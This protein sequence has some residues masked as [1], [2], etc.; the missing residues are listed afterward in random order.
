M[1]FQAEV[2]R[3]SISSG[4]LRA[5]MAVGLIPLCRVDA[6]VS[7]PRPAD[8]VMERTTLERWMNG[9]QQA[10]FAPWSAPHARIHIDSIR[11]VG[12]N[13]ALFVTLARTGHG[14]DSATILHDAGGQ[15]LRLG[16]GLAAYKKL[17]V[18]AAGDSARFERS[19]RF[20]VDGHLSL[21]ATRLWDLVRTFPGAPRRG[22]RWTDTL[23]RLAIDPPYRQSLIGSRVSQILGDTVLDGRRLWVVRDSASVHYEERFE[24]HERTL[25]VTVSIT[26]QVAGT[27]RG[28][29]LYDPE[30]RLFRERADTTNL[31]GTAVLQ[32][33]D[34]RSFRTPTRF[35]R[36]RSWRLYDATRYARYRDSLNARM[37]S[38]RGGMVVPFEGEREDPERVQTARIAAGDT[39]LL[40]HRLS[41]RAY[42]GPSDTANVRA[43]LAFMRDPGLMWDF[44]LPRDWLYENLA[45]S[46]TLWPPALASGSA[47]ERVGC[48]PD[49]C[50]LLA[51]QW[52]DDAAREPRLRDV[53]LIA[54]F[55]LDPRRWAD[56][57]LS[58]GGDGRRPLLRDAVMLARGVGATWPAAAK[59]EMPPPQ[60]DWRVWLEWMNGKN[61][62]ARARDAELARQ[63]TWARD[64]VTRPRVQGSHRTAI[65]MY[66]IRTGRD[67]VGELRRAYSS[68][69][70]DTARLVFGTMLQGLGALE[71][72]DQQI[73]EAFRSGDPSRGALARQ[74]LLA[75]FNREARALDSGVAASL[76][77]RV[78]EVLV[79]TASLWRATPDLDRSRIPRRPTLH[80]RPTRILVR[81]ASL[82]PAVREAWRGRIEIV[83]DSA[84][85]QLDLRQAAVVYSIE[86][87]VGWG[88]FAMITVSASEQ[89]GRPAEDAPEH[90]AAST[91]YYLMQLD[92]EWVL[93]SWSAWVT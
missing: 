25:N 39:N 28:I 12:D 37:A 16:V 60:S 18:P 90:Y 1:Y 2:K 48:V 53:G 8:W 88:P 14:R 32:Y 66:S 33:P 21:P 72:T 76:V 83:G 58:L 3:M 13:R 11:A 52:D 36:T 30:L 27:E 15:V 47:S 59:H 78:L 82:S 64:T 84:R 4:S 69:T 61:A 49:A 80:A 40:Y 29:L 24:E 89:I 65:L 71:L 45:Q 73:V 55:T 62:E 91:T 54:R 68:A 67:I 77:H 93:V 63:Y 46:L 86:Q 9:R 22:A 85:R 41:N 74:V 20:P 57:V 42:P 23:A 19:R 35:N 6:Q 26:R 38:Q 70:S 50:R 34:G 79:D 43:M 87:P 7:L 51:A 56:T 17:G 10:R 92:G 5:L 81:G 44:N 31:T 75:R